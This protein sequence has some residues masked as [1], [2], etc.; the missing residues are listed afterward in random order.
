MKKVFYVLLIISC[1]FLSACSNKGYKE[2][3]YK[4]LIK[5]VENKENFVLTLEA[6]SCIN[7]E[8]FKGTITEITEK[9]NIVTYYIDLDKLTEEEE[10]NISKLFPYRGTPTTINIENGVEKNSLSRIIGASDYLKIKEKL[11]SWNYIEE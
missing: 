10:E 2:L 7:C 8:M 3:S 9:Y 6:A 4:E 1:F 11:V 5:K